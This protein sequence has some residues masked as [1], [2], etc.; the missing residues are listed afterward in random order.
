MR[1]MNGWLAL[2]LLAFA[3]ACN[4]DDDKP[5]N[6]IT[7]EEAAVIVS[8]SFASNTSGVAFVAGE[9][10]DATED[11]VEENEAG[12]VAA[13]G[14]S[15]NLNLSGES[16]NGAAITWSYDFSYKFKL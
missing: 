3:M 14:I 12:R 1:K 2:C 5:A 13:C 16:P 10:A 8:S 11:M 9:S 4:D 6:A 7:S 15:K